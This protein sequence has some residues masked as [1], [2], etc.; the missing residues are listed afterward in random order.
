MVGRPAL[1]REGCLFWGL[2]TVLVL[3][4]LGTLAYVSLITP[5]PIPIR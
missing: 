3:L 1:M 5:D 2:I 4:A